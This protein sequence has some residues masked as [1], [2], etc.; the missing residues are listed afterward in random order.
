MDW[1]T[2][3]DYL[4]KLDPERAHDYVMKYLALKPKGKQPGWAK[5]NNQVGLAAGFDKNAKALWA[6]QQMGFGFVEVG[7]ATLL[8]QIGN[9]KPRIARVEDSL[10]LINRMGFP[11]DGIDKIAQ[12]VRKAKSKGLR[13]PVY[14]SI[15]KGI[16]TDAKDAPKEYEEMTKK[17]NGHAD[18]IVINISSPNTVGLRELQTDM[19]ITHEIIA[20]VVGKAKE[21]PVF[22]KLGLEL[23]GP[24]FGNIISRAS[25]YGVQ[26]IIVGNTIPTKTGGLSGKLVREYATDKVKIVRALCD[27]YSIPTVIGS[28]GVTDIDS[29]IEKLDAGANKVQIYTGLVYKG[30]GLVREIVEATNGR[31]TNT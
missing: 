18:G 27:K 30:P 13:V 7:T 25:Q 24:Q 9:V 2:K 20:R 3:R 10:S 4:F 26:G 14:I 28:G 29:A 31:G 1:A 16:R 8:P 12:R 11:N 22:I 21:K 19:G 23:N 17:I 6:W 5:N 15:G